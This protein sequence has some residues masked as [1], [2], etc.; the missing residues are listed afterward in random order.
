MTVVAILGMHRS[1]TSWLTGELQG[2]GLELGDVNT[3]AK[4]NTHGNRESRFLMR[5]HE[6]VL[7]ENGGSWRLPRYPNK[8]SVE[9][10]ATLRGYI[11]SMSQRY[12]YWGF[13][14][15][16]AVLLI[17]EWARQVGTLLRIGIYRHPRSVYESL[18]HRNSD[19]SEQE[20]FELWRIYNER[21]IAE[22]QMAPF[23]VIRFDVVPDVLADQLAQVVQTLDL[24]RSSR[25]SRFY[26]RQLIHNEVS[27]ASVPRELED[28]WHS[29]E[30]LRLRT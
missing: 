28:V 30:C 29:L 27:S 10:S 7:R 1:G 8:W 16:R 3:K 12:D 22:H 9:Q 11:A 2:F 19:F 26:D 18:H 15:P 24:P 4:Y 17:D 21:L 13:K 23:P 25:S 14:D 5:L 6:E 20:A